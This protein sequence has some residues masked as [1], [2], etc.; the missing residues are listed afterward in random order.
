[1]I[2]LIAAAA[3]WFSVN[4]PQHLLVDIDGGVHGSIELPSP[5]LYSVLFY[6]TTDC[7]IAN[8]YAPEIR[9]ICADFGSKGVQC[10]LVY[11]D[12]QV[13]LETI[14]QHAAEYYGNCCPAIPDSEHV[15]VKQAGATV[16]SEVAVFSKG[17]RLHYRGRIDDLY[18]ALGTP[19]P[20]VTSR[21]LRDALDALISGGGVRVPRTEAFGCFL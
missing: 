1:M 20:V 14:R 11:A 13:P 18:A 17:A 6:L 8:Q 2:V 5:H 10:F 7:P 19:R 12:Q 15:L 4:T 9:R 3:I 16:S 21:D